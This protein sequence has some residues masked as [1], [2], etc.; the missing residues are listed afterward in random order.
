MEG[1]A[2]MSAFA[3]PVQQIQ[4]AGYVLPVLQHSRLLPRWQ[5]RIAMI[6][7]LPKAT[8]IIREALPGDRLGELNAE[9]AAL[10]Y[11][12]LYPFHEQLCS[13]LDAPRAWWIRML[14]GW[15][16]KRLNAEAEALSDIVET[17]AWGSDPTLRAVIDAGVAEL[18]H[19]DCR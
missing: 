19:Q 10:M 16:L 2:D 7:C 3:L 14:L 9:Q 1:R 6:W 4:A 12:A 13:V 8:R 18:Q 15:W 5:S 17:L 11:A